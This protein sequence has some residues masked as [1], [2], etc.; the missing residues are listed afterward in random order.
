VADG[1]NFKREVYSGFAAEVEWRVCLVSR[2]AKRHVLETRSVRHTYLSMFAFNRNFN[3]AH[4]HSEMHKNRVKVSGSRE[5]A[6]LSRCHY[7]WLAVDAPA[8]PDVSN[9]CMLVS[10]HNGKRRTLSCSPHHLCGQEK[11]TTA[12]SINRGQDCRG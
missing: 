10:N 5:L 9:N 2:H 7:G 3:V 12:R 11:G 1:F 6:H 4:T 8:S